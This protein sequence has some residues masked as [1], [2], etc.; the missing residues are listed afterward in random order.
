M[1]VCISN[2]NLHDI[3]SIYM[4]PSSLDPWAGARDLIP[5]SELL[6]PCRVSLDRTCFHYR[7]LTDAVRAAVS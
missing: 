7:H 4:M 5:I 3:S 6:S 1:Y 2:D